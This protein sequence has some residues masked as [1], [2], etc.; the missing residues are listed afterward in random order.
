M[1][2]GAER[3]SGSPN[4]S[5]ASPHRNVAVAD[6]EQSDKVLHAVRRHAGAGDD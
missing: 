6:P 3:L 4:W 1:R 5:A 2:R